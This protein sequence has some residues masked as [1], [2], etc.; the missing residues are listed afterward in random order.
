MLLILN[1]RMNGEK[2]SNIFPSVKEKGEGNNEFYHK[3]SVKHKKK[4]NYHKKLV[5]GK[6]TD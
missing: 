6:K 5:K 2:K 4:G 3:I 1:I